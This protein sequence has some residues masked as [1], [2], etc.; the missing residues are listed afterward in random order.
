MSSRGRT[1]RIPRK[2]KSLIN[3]TRVSLL[4]FFFFFFFERWDNLID[5]FYRTNRS[6]RSVCDVIF[7]SLNN[8]KIIHLI[9]R[10]K[11]VILTICVLTYITV[12]I[13]RVIYCCSLVYVNSYDTVFE[14]VN[15]AGKWNGLY[16]SIERTFQNE[17]VYRAVG[18][19]APG[20]QIPPNLAAGLF[21]T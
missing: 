10:F 13:L 19:R 4:V 6:L 2:I 18:S 17:C 11:F 20:R 5:Y 21:P 14:S 1:L 12:I 15:E 7:I 16:R 9:T 8:I 3:G